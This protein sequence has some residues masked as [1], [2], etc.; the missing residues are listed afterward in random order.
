MPSSQAHIHLY[1]CANVAV[2]NAVINTNPNFFTTT[3][4][5]LLDMVEVLVTL[6]SNPIVHRLAFAFMYL[7]EDEPIQNYIVHL[8]AVAV[9]CNFICPS[10]EYDLS[11]IYIKDQTI[12]GIANH[13]LQADLLAKDGILKSLEQ[14]VRHV[15]AFE[16]ALR[17]QNSRCGLC[18]A[19]NISKREKYSASQRG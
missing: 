3:P 8:R 7:E 2:Q 16:S 17:D 1:N 4:D 9:E 13:T 6:R 10:C 5:K 14:N 12:R 11:D 19:I 18:S 15:E